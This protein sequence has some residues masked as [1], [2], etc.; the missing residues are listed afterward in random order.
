MLFRSPDG[1]DIIAYL[2]TDPQKGS[3]SFSNDGSFVYVPNKDFYGLDRFVYQVADLI[4]KAP[5]VTATINVTPSND[6]PVAN[7]DLYLGPPNRDLII[8]IDSLISNDDDPDGD[9]LIV[10]LLNDPEVGTFTNDE[11][12]KFKYTPNPDFSGVVEFEYFVSDGELNSEQIGR[13]HV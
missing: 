1:V 10:N 5:A 7:D 6:E 11:E 9:E 2:K 12:G 4:G 8:S 13:A 3:L